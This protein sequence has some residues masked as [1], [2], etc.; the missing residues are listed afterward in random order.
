MN[1]LFSKLLDDI[2]QSNE[3]INTLILY[4]CETICKQL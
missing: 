1:S 3:L 2:A 4:N